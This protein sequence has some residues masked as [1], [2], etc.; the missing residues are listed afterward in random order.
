MPQARKG[1]QE[2]PGPQDLKVIREALEL[3][4]PLARRVL[5]VLMVSR[6]RPDLKEQPALMGSREPQDQLVLREIKDHL[7]S[8]ELQ[9][10][11]VLLA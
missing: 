1:P 10:R 3:L 5:R 7:E 11:R 4:V 8:Q 6:G 2:Q 9:G